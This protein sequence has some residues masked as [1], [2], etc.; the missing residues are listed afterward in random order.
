M[1]RSTSAQAGPGQGATPPPADG[2]P[3]TLG[4]RAGPRRA[5]RVAL[6][7]ASVTLA[8]VAGTGWWFVRF[9]SHL[10]RDPGAVYRGPT[11]LDRVLK[12]AA[13]AER[14]GD[15]APASTTLRSVAPVG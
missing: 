7:L 5:R 11:T 2:A 4:Q 15:R 12:P 1:D 14:A 3:S 8:L 10:R 6:L 9:A 13:C